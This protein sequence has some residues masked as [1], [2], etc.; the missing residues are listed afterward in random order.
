MPFPFLSP[1][2]RNWI[3]YFLSSFY[4]II[5]RMKED[6]SKSQVLYKSRR[7]LTCTWTPPSRTWSH[8]FPVL[9]WQL[10]RYICTTGCI[11]NRQSWKHV[12]GGTTHISGI[13]VVV[14]VVVVTCKSK[15]WKEYS[16]PYARHEVI[17]GTRRKDPYTHLGTTWEVT[18]NFAPRPFQHQ[19]KSDGYQMSRRLLINVLG[20]S[21]VAD[22]G[23]TRTEVIPYV[24]TLSP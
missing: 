11:N 21:L 18:A 19:K 3:L 24:S 20:A 17:R 5:A 1:Y 6:V 7:A 14:V 2:P 15:H 4:D 23:I 22:T 16:F 9:G 13:V 12:H 10:L 8:A